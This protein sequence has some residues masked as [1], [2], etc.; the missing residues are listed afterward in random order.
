MKLNHNIY[1]F[2]CHLL[3]FPL[4]ECQKIKSSSSC[5]IYFHSNKSHCYIILALISFIKHNMVE[6]GDC[7]KEVTACWSN[8]EDIRD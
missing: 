2:S 1:L 5:I 8:L 6:L 3:H 4:L 7:K